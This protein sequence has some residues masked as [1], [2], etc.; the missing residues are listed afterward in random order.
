MTTDH[1]KTGFQISPETSCISDIPQP[2]KNAQYKV[3]VTKNVTFM[4]IIGEFS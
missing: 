1:V 2:M 3:P 4:I